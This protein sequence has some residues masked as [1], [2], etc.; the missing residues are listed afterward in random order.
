MLMLKPQVQDRPSIEHAAIEE[1]KMVEVSGFS[2]T[3]KTELNSRS[4]YH[5]CVL[6]SML[7]NKPKLNTMELFCLNNLN[8]VKISTRT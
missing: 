2:E 3:P 7:E 5:F 4:H 8:Q 1:E 6:R